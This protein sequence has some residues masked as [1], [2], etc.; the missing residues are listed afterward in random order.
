M[1]Q[2]LNRLD[3]VIIPALEVRTSTTGAGHSFDNNELDIAG[4]VRRRRR[5]GQDGEIQAPWH[6]YGRHLEK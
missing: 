5:L 4:C 3:M 6:R 1:R 2:V